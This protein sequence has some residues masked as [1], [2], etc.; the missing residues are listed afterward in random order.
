MGNGPSLKNTNL[1]L[2]IGEESWASGRI[3]LLFANTE[4]RPTRGWWGEWPKGAK[5]V[6]SIRA[7]LEEDYPYWMR[8]DAAAYLLEKFIPMDFPDRPLSYWKLQL[9]FEFPRH[10]HLYDWCGNRHAGMIQDS[11]QANMP[12][13]WHPPKLC[14]FGSTTHIMLQQAVFE[15]YKKVY[16]I[17]TDL[18]FT[19]G[20][21][22][23]FAPDYQLRPMDAQR[24][25]QFNRTHVRAHKIAKFSARFLGATIFNAT[26][27]GELEVY[28]RVDFDSLF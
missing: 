18:G 14:R 22:N 28:P 23:H 13:S 10:P 6:A 3:D 11:D 5:D 26:I 2:L 9:P 17:G 20:E 21:S 24:A 25:D 15:G 7:N 1:E 8:S 27:G 4:W 19:E 16:L 12:E